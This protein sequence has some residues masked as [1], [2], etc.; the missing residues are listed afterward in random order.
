MLQW[1]T[2]SAAVVTLVA[3]VL[4]AGLLANFTWHV[5]TATG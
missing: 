4:L 5:L 1:N 2:K 3:L